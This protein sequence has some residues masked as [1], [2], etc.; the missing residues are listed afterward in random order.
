MTMTIEIG[1]GIT[2]G[3]GINLNAN[4]A[5]VTTTYITTLSG[6]IITTVS[7]DKLITL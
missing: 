7:G 2:I 4:A 3:S 1:S 5:P 6:L